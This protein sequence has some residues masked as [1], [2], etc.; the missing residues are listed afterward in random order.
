MK[1]ETDINRI[2]RLNFGVGVD[3]ESTYCYVPT[4]TEMRTTFVAM[5]QETVNKLS[6]LEKLGEVSIYSPSEKH[7]AT[8]YLKLNIDS[9]HAKAIQS[10]FTAK[11][12]E[13]NS[14]IMGKPKE[15]YSY[16]CDVEDMLGNRLLAIRRAT[17]FTALIKKRNRVLEFITDTLQSYNGNL[18]VLDNDFDLL[19]ENE[20][21]HILRPSS[22]E[23]I[24]KLQDEITAS[25]SVNVQRL[26]KRLKYVNF[27]SL[28]SYAKKHTRAARYIASIVSRDDLEKTDKK[29]L[30]RLCK[31]TDVK[32]REVQKLIDIG[33]G[34]EMGFLE[35]L[36]RRRFDIELVAGQKEKYRASSRTKI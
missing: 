16:F 26:K 34:S 25:V 5:L 19:V 6:S 3:D 10:L 18:F 36:D 20:T 23:F 15:I 11:N 24:S 9:S 7:A 13:V 29:N 2:N 30:I 28:E 17:L 4:R 14:A 8:E 21:I 22:F 1:L 33:K 35:V 31:E 27:S 32:I 12:I